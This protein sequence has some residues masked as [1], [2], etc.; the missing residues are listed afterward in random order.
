MRFQLSLSLVRASSG[1]SRISRS[2]GLTH[3]MAVDGVELKQAVESDTASLLNGQRVIG[4]LKFDER[5]LS[6]CLRVHS[7]LE[8]QGIRVTP[9]TVREPAEPRSQRL[10]LAAVEIFVVESKILS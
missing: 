6:H 4:R 2:D 7:A 5:T 3:V 1:W 10:P 9:Q 8:V